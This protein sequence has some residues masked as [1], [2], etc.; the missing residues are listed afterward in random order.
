MQEKQVRR[1]DRV[2]LSVP[3][4]VSGADFTGDAFVE[5]TKTLVISRHGATIVLSKKLNPEQGLTIRPLSAEKEAEFRVVG[6]MG[7]Q[8]GSF[9]YGVAL[10][11]Q[12]L[13]V[14]HIE[15]P[16]LTESEK[17][18]G[19]VLLECSHCQTREVTYLNELELEIFDA[20]ESIKRSCKSCASPTLWGPAMREL[21][22]EPLPS[23]AQSSVVSAVTP[24]PQA[25]TQEERKEIRTKLKMTVCIR[26]PGF[27]E[28][29]TVT[30]DVSRAG[31]GFRSRKQYLEGSRIEIALPYRPEAG[32]IFVPARI[33]HVAELP[34]GEPTR[35]GARY[36]KF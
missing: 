2:W 35:Y 1:S 31:L 30:E 12:S 13:N 32:N 5:Q 18:V 16:P 6:Q 4:K 15:F 10:R 19:R 20:N 9:I 36:V 7:G 8:A 3:I 23:Q 24:V 11:E 28:E 26:Q 17:A 34:G 33:A 22:V 29:V 14:W 21:P 27:G 25:R